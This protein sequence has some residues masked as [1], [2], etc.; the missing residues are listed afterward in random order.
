[1]QRATRSASATVL[2][3][4]PIWS[5]KI[6]GYQAVTADSTVAW[7]KPNHAAQRTWLTDR[8]TSIRA[9]RNGSDPCCACSTTAG[10]ASGG[11]LWIVWV[12]NRPVDTGFIGRTHCEL[13]HVCGRDNHRAR[14]LES[15]DG[16]GRVW[17]D[18][19]FEHAGT[20][21][22]RQPLDA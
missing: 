21:G 20:R 18:K 13:V 11:S 4:G 8:S 12:A 1:M 3:S 10:T 14:L 5:R 2:V 16:G 22:R 19:A 17:H 6:Q 7:L 15:G 9:N